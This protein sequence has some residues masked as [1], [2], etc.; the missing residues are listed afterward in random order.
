[1]HIAQT[2]K[3]LNFLGFEGKGDLSTYLSEIG[4]RLPTTKLV[5]IMNGMMICGGLQGEVLSL[6]EHVDSRRDD[7]LSRAFTQCCMSMLVEDVIKQRDTSYAAKVVEL[8][9]K[10]RTL[11]DL[12]GGAKGTYARNL[13]R[14]S[15]TPIIERNFNERCSQV[16][17]TGLSNEWS[18][19]VKLVSQS[20]YTT[21]YY[22]DVYAAVEFANRKKSYRD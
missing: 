3:E 11:G 13:L 8:A 4:E 6:S 22:L 19:V 16:K 5:G 7:R 1:M 20:G 18:T 9:L 2:V 14:I 15:A 12:F 21:N 17:N 10:H